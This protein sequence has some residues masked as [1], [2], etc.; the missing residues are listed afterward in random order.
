MA[1]TQVDLLKSMPYASLPS[2][3]YYWTTT[4]YTESTLFTSDANLALYAVT[5]EKLITRANVDFE[6]LRVKR[7]PGRANIVLQQDF[8]FGQPG[9]QTAV[10]N[11]FL[12]N[13]ARWTL[14]DDFGHVTYRLHRFPLGEGEFDG[15]KLTSAAYAVQQNMLNGFLFPARWYNHHGN[16]LTSGQ[17]SPL[18]HMWQ[19]RHGTKRRRSDFWL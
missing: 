6:G 9:A 8:T 13:I 16:V 7:P 10:A 3:R 4:L 14:R 18:V 11:P 1:L 2:G 17:V 15:L 19:L 12:I 5:R